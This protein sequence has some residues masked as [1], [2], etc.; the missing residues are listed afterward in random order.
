M[1]KIKLRHSD[2]FMIVDMEDFNELSKYKWRLAKIKG[3]NI[4]HYYAV[5]TAKNINGVQCTIFAH[6]QIMEAKKGQFVDHA[7]HNTLNNTKNNLRICTCSENQH[8]LIGYGGKKTS[9]Y[10]GVHLEKVSKKWHAQIKIDGKTQHIGSFVFEIDA[11]KAYDNKAREL[12]G[13]FACLNFN[14]LQEE[15]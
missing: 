1:E 15:N 12:F 6:R 9:K 13:K 10:K 14:N 3:V 5:R 2:L 8:N 7:D 4:P 11:A